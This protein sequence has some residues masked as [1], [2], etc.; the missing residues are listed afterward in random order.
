MASRTKA[1]ELTEYFVLNVYGLHPSDLFW[2]LTRNFS[3]SEVHFPNLDVCCDW[4]TF[5]PHDSGDVRWGG[6]R[7]E[8]R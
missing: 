3:R 4:S 5:F 7:D 6:L 2:S 1:C 8:P